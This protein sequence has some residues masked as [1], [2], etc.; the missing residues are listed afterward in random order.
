M[1]PA[2]WWQYFISSVSCGSRKLYPIPVIPPDCISNAVFLGSVTFGQLLPLRHFQ[3]HQEM[4]RHEKHISSQ[5]TWH[6][7][8]GCCGGRCNIHISSGSDACYGHRNPATATT[9]AGA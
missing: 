3:K 8:A 9:T 5:I 4:P 6:N 7:I 2:Q 1:G